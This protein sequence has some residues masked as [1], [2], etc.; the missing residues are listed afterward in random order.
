M[1][2]C[3]D[4]NALRALAVTAVVLYHYKVIF[5]PGGF[6]GVDVR[7]SGAPGSSSKL[8]ARAS[9]LATLELRDAAGYTVGVTAGEYPWLNTIKVNDEDHTTNVG[10]KIGGPTRSFSRRQSSMNMAD[11]DSSADRRA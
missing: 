1:K 2:F 4:I 7:P 11:D 3:D 9:P 5:I 10:S 8:V 6:V